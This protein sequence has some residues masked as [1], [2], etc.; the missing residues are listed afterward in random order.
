MDMCF[1]EVTVND[2]FSL[3]TTPQIYNLCFRKETFDNVKY[4]H[5]ISE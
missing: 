5:C 2:L 4:E 3:H 1:S